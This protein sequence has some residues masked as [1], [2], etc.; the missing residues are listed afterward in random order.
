MTYKYSGVRPIS[1]T[2][3][4]GVRF[5]GKASLSLP[6]GDTYDY[7]FLSSNVPAER[8]SVKIRLNGKVFYDAP[9]RI[10]DML[11]KYKGLAQELET[12]KVG[13]VY[14]IPFADLSMRL[15]DGQNLT[16]LV[17]QIGESLDLE[18]SIA[19][20]E[21]G[22]PESAYLSAHPLIGLPRAQRI[23]LPRL[24]VANIPTP[25]NGTNQFSSLPNVPNR[26]VRRMHFENGHIRRIDIKRDDDEAYNTDCFLERFRATRNGKQWQDGWTHLD[27]VQRGYIQ[28][29]M[30]PT[31]REK[32]LIFTLEVTR[33]T[34]TIDVYIEYL[35]CEKPELLV[36]GG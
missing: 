23:Y 18:V 15:K 16:G 29:E 10:F 1:V 13:Y 31:V 19:K 24:E 32:Q 35:D 5:N 2:S 3:F 28:L 11:D 33:T 36:K 34:G 12:E 26:T 7:I 25:S 30:F 8:L 21:E 4:D 14:V 22:D 20:R 27:F 9:M 6:C 17:T